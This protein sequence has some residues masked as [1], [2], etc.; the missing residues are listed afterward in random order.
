MGFLQQ[1]LDQV[2]CEVFASE[3]TSNNGQLL[4]IAYRVP[5]PARECVKTLSQDHLARD[6]PPSKILRWET[7]TRFNINGDVVVDKQSARSDVPNAGLG[8]VRQDS[9]VLLVDLVESVR[10]MCEHEASCVRRWAD[11]VRLVN[12]ET[13]PR[14]YDGKKPR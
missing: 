6:C 14:H 1:H 7:A 2:F 11:F 13:L 10:L 9:V 12:S 5:G 3:L 8:L 4:C